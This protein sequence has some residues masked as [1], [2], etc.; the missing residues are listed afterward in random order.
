MTVTTDRLIVIDGHVDVARTDESWS[1][2]VDQA[3]AGGVDVI[4]VPARVG[5]TSRDAPIVDAAQEQ[6]AT[7]EGLLSAVETSA[8]RARFAA[9]PEEVRENAERGILSVVLGFQNARPLADLAA[10]ERWIDRSVAVFDFGFAGSNQ[11]VESSRPYP[12]ASVDRDGGG[13]GATT[14]EAIEL[15]NRRGVIIDTAQVSDAARREIVAASSAPVIAS[16]NGVKA[17]VP[18]ADRAISDEDIV[19]IADAGGLVQIVAFD[20]YHTPRGSHP[21]VVADIR[22]LRERFGLPGF[23]SQSDYYALLDPESAEWGEQK[24]NDYFHEYHAKVR[25]DW[26][27]TDLD[28]FVDSIAHVA[29][30]VGVDHVGIAS[31]FH[32]GGG[33]RGWLAPAETANVTEALRRRFDEGDVVKIWGGNFLRVWEDVRAA[34]DS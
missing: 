19:A 26:P 4:V 6:E 12:H 31:D 18:G 15:L 3:I 2:P 17:R 22:E 16:H 8:G 28:G 13:I 27:R 14:R 20:G 24:F 23:V 30:L 7:Y 9:S 1:F 32:H 34:A 11:W 29:D 25:H 33:V 21:Q 10:V 5:L